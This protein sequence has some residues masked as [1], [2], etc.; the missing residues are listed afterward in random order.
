MKHSLSILAKLH[1]NKKSRNYHLGIYD[2]TNDS[3]RG[4][5]V[6]DFFLKLFITANIK[7]SFMT[8]DKELSK[9]KVK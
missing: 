9:F 1:F 6:L 7:K 3:D 4:K 2:S 5:S 8:N